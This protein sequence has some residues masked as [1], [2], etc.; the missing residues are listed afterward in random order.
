MTFGSVGM[1]HSSLA[2]MVDAIHT[3]M[4]REGLH[5]RFTSSAVSF[6]QRCVEYVLKQRVNTMTVL[7]SHLLSHF[8]NIKIIDSTSWGVDP[9]LRHV[10]PGSG[11][12]ASKANCKVQLCYEYLHGAISFFD[13]VPGNTPDNGYAENLPVHFSKGDLLMADLGY[14]CLG[15]LTQIIKNGAFFVYRFLVGT[16]LYNAKT[17]KEIDL[18]RILQKVTGAAYEM[19]VSMGAKIET[20]VSCRL[21]CLRA[22]EKNAAERRR[23]LRKK[24]REKGRV[25]SEIHLYM[26]GWILMVTNVPS[27]WLPP[28]MVRQ[29]YCLRWQIE[30]LFKQLKSV[31]KVHNSATGKENRLRC[32]LLGKLFVAVI[33]HRI[34]A[35][36][37]I[38]LWNTKKQEVSM[39]KLYKRFQE[40]AF[41][42]V[43]LFCSSLAKAVAYLKNELI[44]LLKNCRKLNQKSRPTTLQKL[45]QNIS[46]HP[47]LYFDKGILT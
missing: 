41:R 17:M 39:D 32:E 7:D 23:K 40:R 31:L 5:L 6:M 45:D 21:I 8:K 35:D 26:A 33:I 2:A 15:S 47:D 14:F 27:K 19:N 1:L 42:L 11:G 24:A 25:V 13:V 34:H 20:R 30:L 3:S 28:E 44:W 16:A 29:L 10:L 12:S 22:D 46:F 43:D 9:V 37:N 36:I 38:G 18:R 4:S